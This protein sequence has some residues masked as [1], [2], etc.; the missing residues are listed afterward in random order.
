MV[1][2]ASFGPDVRPLFSEVEQAAKLEVQY[3]HE[4]PPISPPSPSLGQFVTPPEGGVPQE[5]AAGALGSSKRHG[6]R[7]R[8]LYAARRGE[9]R[10]PAFQRAHHLGLGVSGARL[11][12]RSLLPCKVWAGR[13]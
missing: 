12:C 13:A 7:N 10:E 4:G 9:A 11:H 8:E 5:P 6:R 1:S 3:P 2:A